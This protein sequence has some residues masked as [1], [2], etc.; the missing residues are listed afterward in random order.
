VCSDRP[1]AAEPSRSK[2]DLPHEPADALGD[3]D[4][5]RPADVAAAGA[6]ADRHDNPSLGAGNR[7]LLPA[8]QALDDKA[9]HGQLIGAAA[10]VPPA[11]NE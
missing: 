1:H 10:L 9:L 6:L 2:W 7:P 8:R 4:R 11:S 3:V 5:A